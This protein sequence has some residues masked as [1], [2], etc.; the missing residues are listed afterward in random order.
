VRALAKGYY[1]LAKDGIVAEDYETAASAATKADT[2][3]R[4]AKD[5]PLADRAA[6]LKKDIATLKTEYGKVKAAI[7][8]PAGGDLDAVGRYLCF[9]RN[10]WPTGLKILSDGGKSPLKELAG[11]D[12]ANPSGV[13]A[14]AEV[15]DGWWT[16]AQA[17][18]IPW[19][20]QNILSRARHWYEQALPASTG[21]VKIRLTKR[22]AEL[23]NVAPG[24]GINLMALIDPKRDAVKGEW[25]LEEGF[26][27]NKGD[28]GVCLQ[29]PFQPPDEYDLRLTLKRFGS[30]DSFWIGLVAGN[31]QVTLL[32]DG[33]PANAV[34]MSG[35]EQI[36]G[37]F[38]T[39]Q[40]GAIK[41]PMS[42]LPDKI[43]V[44]EVSVRKSSIVVTVDGKKLVGYEGQ[45]GKLGNRPDAKTPD[46]KALY[47]GGWGGKS[48]FGEIRITPLSGPGKKTK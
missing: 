26:L 36:D 14:Q 40:P 31:T 9:V 18:K 10:E 17:E 27:I 8:N 39:G 11:K 30:V 1:E 41:G 42:V 46:G 16:Q 37:R 43:A 6:E 23:E 3:A 24:G 32:I 4:A 20:K 12:L 25:T 29:I 19:K 47:V 35:F 22:M 13:D 2:L 44:V 48:G 33:Y 34:Y 21:L 7:D 45:F 5:A 38:L 28:E 15:G